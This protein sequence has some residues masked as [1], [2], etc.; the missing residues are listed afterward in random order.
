MYLIMLLVFRW[1]ETWLILLVVYSA[2]VAPF[3]FG[4]VESPK[5]PLLGFDYAVNAFFGIDIVVTFF[6]AYFDRQTFLMV[7]NLKKI[8]VR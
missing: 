4:F 5:G 6:V 3:E 8:A 2:W 7:D 1:W